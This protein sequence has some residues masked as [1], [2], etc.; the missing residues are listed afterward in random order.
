MSASLAQAEI[1]LWIPPLAAF[2]ISLFTSTAGVSGA[3]LLLPLQTA[4][5]GINTPSVSATNQL[6]NVIAIPGGVYRFARERKIIYPLLFIIAAGSVPGVV[7]GTLIRVR[8]LPDSRNFSLFA[9]LVL[10]TLALKLLTDLFARRKKTGAENTNTHIVTDTRCSGARLLCTIDGQTIGLNWPAL[11]AAS[12]LVGLVGGIYGIGGG[13][14]IVPIL[15]AFTRFPIHAIAGAALASTLTT[16]IVAVAAFALLA[17]L[18]PE[19]VVEPNWKYGILFGLG[20]FL[21]IYCGAR[22]QKFMPATIIKWIVTLC[23]LLA[24]GKY[25]WRYFA[26]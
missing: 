2:V 1:S 20:G 23:A 12:L 6:Y 26:G 18:Y 4:L 22:L 11:M 5:L 25:I 14:F 9:G 16:S 17:P 3:F 10:A 21:G 8:Y 19:T 15:V 13:A 24:A 7:A